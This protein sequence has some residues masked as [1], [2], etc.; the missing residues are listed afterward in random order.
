MA[1]ICH[2]GIEHAVSQTAW[3]SRYLNG[4]FFDYMP[5][6]LPDVIRQV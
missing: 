5:L 1:E 4:A 6:N 2:A 3:A